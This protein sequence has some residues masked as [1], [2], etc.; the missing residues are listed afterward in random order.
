MNNQVTAS[1]KLDHIKICLNN[2]V[3]AKNKTTGFEDVD[4]I[5][6]AL[7]ELDLASIN[8]KNKLFGHEFTVPIIISAMTGGH[9]VAEKINKILA[10]AAQELGIGL[11]LGS[12]RAALE[13]PQL[14]KTYSIAREYAPD[15]FLIGNIGAPQLADGTIKLKEAKR[16]IELIDGNAL[17]IHLNALQEAIQ[18]EGDSNYSGVIQA[19]DKLTDELEVPIIAKETG[20]G[21]SREIASRIEKAGVAG[22]DIQGAGGTSFSAV[23]VYRAEKQGLEHLKRLG[24][25]FWDWGLPTAVSTVEVALNTSQMEIIASGGI[26]NGLEMAKAMALGAEGVGIASPLLAPA[27]SGDVAAVKS[28]IDNF[29]TELK[30]A[31]F[32]TGARTIKDLKKVPCVISGRSASF[33]AARG[34]DISMFAQRSPHKIS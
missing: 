20:A 23:E 6:C 10:I 8:I 27:F 34:I 16:L 28:V 19:I 4:F 17:A 22:I 18:P 33:L 2:D 12:Q 1:R 32:L 5:H 25:V 3:Q 21:I 7:P 26:R 9:P 29:I 14:E 24:T 30:C 11:G 13:N 15:A 31:M